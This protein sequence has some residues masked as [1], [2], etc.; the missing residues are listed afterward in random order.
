MTLLV[1]KL[2]KKNAPLSLK[3]SKSRRKLAKIAENLQKP[4]QMCENRLKQ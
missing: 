4:S 1:T 3:I 2:I